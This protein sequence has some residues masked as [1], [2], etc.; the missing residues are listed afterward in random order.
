MPRVRPSEHKAIVKLLNEPADSVEE[1]AA[2]VIYTLNEMRE[3]RTDW[4][5]VVY[6]PGVAFHVHGPYVTRNAAEK[7]IGKGVFAASP[8]AKYG[9]YPLHTSDEGIEGI[10]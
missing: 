5:V 3:Q 6:D 4:V 10:D 2:E 1:L 9:V 7:D 8:G